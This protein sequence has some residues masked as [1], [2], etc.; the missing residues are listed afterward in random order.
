LKRAGSGSP[1]RETESFDRHRKSLHWS[2]PAWLPGLSGYWAPAGLFAVFV[3]IAAYAVFTREPGAAFGNRFPRTGTEFLE[4][5]Q[6]DRKLARLE[7]RTK[8]NPNDI[9]AFFEAGLLKFQKGPGSYIDAISDLETARSRGL[10]DIRTFYY[11]GRMYQAV[12]L[13]EFSLEEYRRFLNNRPEDFEVRMLAAK[14]LF[15]SGK[16]PAAVKEYETLN[17]GNPKNILVLENLAL[18]RWKNNQ[19]PGPIL[20]AMRG[21]GPEA[22]FRAGYVSGRMAY[23][24]KNYAAA[25]PLLERAAAES[26]KYSDFSDRAGVYAMLS[27]SYVKLKSDTAAIAAL[28]ELLKISPANNEARSLLARLSRAQ[29]KKGTKAQSGKGT[30]L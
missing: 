29:N 21:L 17:S 23:E 12:G 19:D 3:L 25:A 13:Y 18:S 6:L 2:H 14:L 24:D 30:K 7:E 15:S 11:L 1:V 20:D 5:G 16:Y 22:V 8:N 28:N 10:A 27:D 26:L 4:E 9:Q